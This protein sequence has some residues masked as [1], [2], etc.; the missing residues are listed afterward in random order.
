L[1]SDSSIIGC[2]EMN[3]F[4]IVATFL[5]IFKQ[6]ASVPIC[7]IYEYLQPLKIDTYLER[8]VYDWRRW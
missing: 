4:L 1:L 2:V 3:W 6:F 7:S 5:L 8:F